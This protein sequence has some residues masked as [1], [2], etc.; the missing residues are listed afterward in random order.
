MNPNKLEPIIE[1]NSEEVKTFKW[2]VQECSKIFYK[3]W[4]YSLHMKM[5]LGIKQFRCQICSKC[6]T[7]K[8]NYNKHLKTHRV[9]NL[10]DRKIYECHICL[11]KYTQAYN[12]RVSLTQISKAIYSYIQVPYYLFF[13]QVKD[14]IC[15]H[16]IFIFQRSYSLTNP[17]YFLT[18]S[19]VT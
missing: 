1:T 10:R 16:I 4:N 6:F 19:F 11:K 9:P 14:L 15:T 5:H 2:A 18:Q 12:L 3:K 13:A 17:F 8:C 7:Q